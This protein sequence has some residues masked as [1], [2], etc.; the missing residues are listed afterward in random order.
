M[1]QAGRF[2]ELIG[3]EYNLTLATKALLLSTSARWKQRIKTS[4]DKKLFALYTEWEGLQNRLANWHSSEESG[5]RKKFDSTLAISEKLEKELSARSESFGKMADNKPVTWKQIQAKLKPGEAAIEMIRFRKLGI[6][7]SV[8]DTSDPKKP[9]YLIKGLSD[10]IYYAA[11]LV[12]AGQSPPEM[13]LL[14]NGDD[15]EGKYLKFYQNSV[16]RQQSDTVSYHQFWE[17]IGK[18]LVN[19]TRVYFSPDGVFHLI[20]LNTLYN[21]KSKKFLLEEKDIRTVTVTKDIVNPG[22]ADEENTLVQLVGF[23]SYYLS[24]PSSSIVIT[25]RKSPEMSYLLRMESVGMLAELPGTKIEVDRISAIFESK[26]WDVK[27]YT[28]E[29]ALEEI[30]KESY[31]PRVLHIATHGFFQPD[32]TKGS[33]PLLRSGLMLAGAGSTL[34]GEKNETGEDGILT[35][36]EAMNLNLDNTDLVVL[37]ACE[38]GLGEVKNGEGVYGLQRAFKVAGARSI[39]M[40]LWKVDDDATQE[41]MVSFYKNWL[42]NPTDSSKLSV[43]SKRQAFLKAQKELKAKYP[44][45][46][47][48][49]AFVMVGE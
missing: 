14:K 19:S 38:T 25:E 37:S 12:K 8:T 48:W 26:G 29:K 22:P 1:Q 15:L 18:K 21:P 4:G 2:P 3:E 47:Y 34:K 28:E 9:N 13:V 11:L 31:K 17:K 24:A 6:E 7:K 23:P 42:E 49:G 16:S 20:N 39:I 44:S 46:Y 43:G 10:T 33:N 36:Y 45:P 41:L 5:N 32:T 30:L 27:N 35:A 40:S